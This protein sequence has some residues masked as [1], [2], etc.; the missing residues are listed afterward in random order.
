MRH[1]IRIGAVLF[2][3]VLVG[4]AC[5]DDDDDDVSSDTEDTQASSDDT[6]ADDAS[7]DDDSSDDDSSDD[8]EDDS[9]D[10]DGG[11]FDRDDAV[12]ELVDSGVTRDQ[13]E[14]YVDGVID[15]FGQDRI[16]EIEGEGDGATPTD[17]EVQA[18]LDIVTGCGVDLSELG[19]L[20]D[21]E[22]DDSTDDTSG[23][24]DETSASGLLPGDTYGDNETLDALW[25]D[26][27]DG[28]G[29]ACLDLYLQSEVGSEYEEF[30]ASCGGRD[31]ELPCA[32]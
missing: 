26:C 14:C 23:S 28:D 31:E 6:Q 22:G 27:E 16:D 18:L 2:A 7:S 10:D 30:G 24:T 29:E 12:D 32:G 4:A 5:G 17:E 25:D 19:G 15:E 21:D 9:D 13:A 1:L 3:L 11:S 20:G 8:T